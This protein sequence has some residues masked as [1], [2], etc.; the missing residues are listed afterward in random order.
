[1]K[2]DFQEL[3]D[4]IN[5]SEMI[6]VVSH[7]RPD[8]DAVGSLLSLSLSLASS[9]KTVNPILVDGLPYRFEFLPGSD[10]VKKD[11]PASWDLLICVD[12]AD[13]ERTGLEK[14]ILQRTP[15]VNIDHHPTNTT[16][17]N[18]NY[19][20][21]HAAAAVEIVYDIIRA[22]KL[23]EDRAIRNNLMA[24]LLADTIGFRTSNVHPGTLRIAA[25]LLDQGADLS[26][27]YGYVLNQRTFSAAKYWGLGLEKVQQLGQLVW[28][29][30]TLADRKV[31]GYSENDDADLIN[32]LS[33]IE[34]TNVTV[35]FI[36]QPNG[37]VKISWRARDG[38]DVAVLAKR[39]GGGGHKPAAGAMVDGSLLEVQ[40]EVLS[41]TKAYI[42]AGRN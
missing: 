34:D 41:A 25:D 33:T 24:G 31:S 14:K 40:D 27:L 15:V 10:L 37:K 7:L 12:C 5:S 21:P 28:A 19:V 23:P 35:L 16:F 32:F 36:E 3:K 20:E 13:F 18:L 29:S 11:L 30:L 8:G 42:N 6:V 4:L 17:G 2:T 26:E 1:V 38:I 39:F 22:L 9:G